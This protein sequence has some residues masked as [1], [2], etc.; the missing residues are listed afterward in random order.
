MTDPESRKYMKTRGSGFRRNDKIGCFVWFCRGVRSSIL[1]ALVLILCPV[2]AFPGAQSTAQYAPGEILVKFKEGLSREYTGGIYRSLGFKA[3]EQARKLPIDRIKIPDGWSVQE[4]VS[5]YRADPDVEYA[6]PNYIRRALLTPNDPHFNQLWGLHN[7][8]Q[9]GGAQ[10]AD[11]DAPEAWD[12][13][14]HCS[15]LVIAV[16][17]TGA[18]LDHEDLKESIWRNT[19]EDWLD[20]SPGNNG[21][22][23]DLNGKVDDYWGW[24]FVNDDNEPSDDNDTSYH[25][26]H[27]AGIISARG[28]NSV[29]ITGVCWSASLMILK[30]LDEDGIGYL[31]SELAA[32]QYAMDN[33]AKIINLSLGAP[34]YSESEYEAIKSARD[35]GVLVIAAAGNGGYDSIG[36]DN[37][38]TDTAE[39]P[40]SYSLDNIISVTATDENDGL[41]SWANYGLSSVDVAAPG[42]DIYGTKAGNEY[43]YL[44]G[45]SMATASVSGL[46]A[47]VWAYHGGLTSA[48]VKA[49]ILNGVDP[50]SS[51]EG[52]I[53]T[54]GRINAFTSLI[55][56]SGGGDDHPCFIAATAY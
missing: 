42:V 44:S 13:Q 30:I 54:S 4:A 17:D 10:D 16:P 50:K 56:F 18:D 27:V 36:D 1:L 29:G 34:G 48:Q 15:G 55:C 35:A 25:G 51:L 14:R 7:T 43:Q 24:D 32:I 40:A 41:P 12:I 47:L 37:D 3:L 38:E 22:D 20:G 21:K 46:A 45:T 49:G 11:M 6:E 26:T 8:G 31:S 23:D 9:T 53:L 33:G 39:Y 2:S 52:K 28:N 5:F 19:G